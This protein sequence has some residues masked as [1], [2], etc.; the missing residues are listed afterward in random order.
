[1][2][3]LQIIMLLIGI[4]TVGITLYCIGIDTTISFVNIILE[5]NGINI[6]FRRE[7]FEV[8]SFGRH[9]ENEML[10][11]T[12]RTA[13]AYVKDYQKDSD[14]ATHSKR[15]LANAMYEFDGKY[16]GKEK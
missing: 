1:M 15:L 4:A 10:K 2:I 16:P 12:I 5:T 11:Q 13:Y 6:R 9:I 3:Y 8:E 7:K 14:M